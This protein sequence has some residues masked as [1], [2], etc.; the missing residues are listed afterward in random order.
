MP[1]DQSVVR[2]TLPNGLRVVVS[3]DHSILAVTVNLCRRRIP[4]RGPRPGRASATSS[5]T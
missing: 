2:H 3:P 4:A 1:L 5:N